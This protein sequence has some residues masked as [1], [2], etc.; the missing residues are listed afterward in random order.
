MTP[1]DH[2]SD[3]ARAG[4]LE[5]CGRRLGAATGDPRVVH[6]K[7]VAAGNR[8]ADPDPAWVNAPTV[9]LSRHDGQPHHGQLNA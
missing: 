4:Q 9:H 1:E 3:A 8:V 5:R 7:D 2:N 6:D